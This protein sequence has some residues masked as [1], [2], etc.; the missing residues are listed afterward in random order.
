MPAKNSLPRK[1]SLKSRVEIETLFSQG[2]RFQG[3]LCTV[4]WQPAES[5][6]YG[7]FVSRSYGSAA[8][9]NQIKRLYREAVRFVR[10]EITEVGKLAILP[11]ATES[12]PS[13]EEIKTDVFRVLE[14]L[15]RRK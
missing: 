2:R 10:P 1:L 4:V 9:R 14:E 5:F 7:V 15:A 8:K 3:K 6:A 13:L 11:K 12:V